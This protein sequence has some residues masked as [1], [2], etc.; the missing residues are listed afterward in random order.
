M[1]LLD[2][3]YSNIM[4]VKTGICENKD[5]HYALLCLMDHLNMSQ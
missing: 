4:K 2:F 3:L 5:L 1:I